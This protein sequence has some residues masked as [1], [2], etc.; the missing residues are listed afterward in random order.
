MGLVPLAEG[1]R[2]DL[3]DAI[4][5]ERLR[6]HELVVRR[7]VDHV[8]NTGLARADLGAPG[9]VARLEAERAELLVA[10][11]SSNF[12]DLLDADFG[13]RRRPPELELALLAVVEALAARGAAL[14][15]NTAGD[16]LW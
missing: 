3:D 2:V 12:G 9:V 8:Q 13:V 11:S 5:H 7:V 1:R 15:L 16:T 6:A 4:L 14:V 10:A